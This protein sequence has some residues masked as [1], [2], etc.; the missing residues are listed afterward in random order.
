MSTPI[1]PYSPIVRAGSWLICSGQLG[2]APIGDQP[3]GSS[4]PTLVEGGVV[5]QLRQALE[6]AAGLLRSE[7]ADLTTVAKTT[8]FLTA[9]GDYPAVNEAYAAFFGDHRPAR[10]VVAVAGLP[11]GA[12]VEVELWA[13]LAGS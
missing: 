13:H 10:S 9:M 7:G 5:A 4:P 8:V 6:N 12:L 2:L 3:D 11:M 1:G